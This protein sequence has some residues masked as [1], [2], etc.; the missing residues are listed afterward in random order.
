M[1]ISVLSHQEMKSVPSASG[2][3]KFG[4]MF[5]AIGDDSPYLFSLNSDF[6]VTGQSLIYP[7]E[8]IENGRIDKAVKPDF[9]GME[10]IGDRTLLIFGSGSK[11]PQRDLCLEVELNG[12]LMV[13]FYD[14]KE[15]YTILK[16]RDEMAGAELNIEA[17][18][19]HDELIFLFNRSNNLIFE[20]NLNELLLYFKGE[21]EIPTIETK[22]FSLPEING[23]ESGFSG[24]TSIAG[25]SYLLFTSSVEDT[26]NAY[27]DGAILG[28]FIGL[29]DL[30][31][32]N[33]LLTVKIPNHD[34]PLKVETVTVDEIISDNEVGVVIATDSDGGVSEVLKA[35]L[36]W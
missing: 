23:I 7:T 15:F 1:K 28:S 20:M 14:L 31:N 22:K 3:V 25:T 35:N 36:S 33:E 8:F 9:E 6:E 5:Y 24:A 11:S 27:D 32:E 19:V 13:N 18:A 30:E 26:D 2:M 21:S 4:D 34:S 29:F 16:D 10:L 12:E 17:T